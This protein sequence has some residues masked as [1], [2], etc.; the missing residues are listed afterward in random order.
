VLLP[1]VFGIQEATQNVKMTVH[2]V[3]L[4]RLQVLVTMLAMISDKV[5]TALTVMQKKVH[6]V[7]Q[8]VI[9]NQKLNPIVMMVI[10]TEKDRNVEM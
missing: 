5:A 10:G 6:V 8:M 3:L 2:V 9:A 7:I 4:M 1:V